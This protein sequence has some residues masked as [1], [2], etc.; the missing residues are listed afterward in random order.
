MAQTVNRLKA[1]RVLEGQ[2]VRVVL[3][4]RFRLVRTLLFARAAPPATTQTCWDSKG[5]M[6]RRAAA[7]T[8]R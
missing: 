5:R 4:T 1:N 2:A 6:L 7:S 8:R 3:E